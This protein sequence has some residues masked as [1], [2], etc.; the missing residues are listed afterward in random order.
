GGFRYIY[1]AFLQEA[2]QVLNNEKLLDLSKEMTLIGDAWRDFALEASRIYKN[3]SGKTD[4]YNKV[5][6]ELEAIAHKEAAF[7]KKLKKAI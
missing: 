6:D 4:A 1:A 5:A 7:F 2:S 3:R